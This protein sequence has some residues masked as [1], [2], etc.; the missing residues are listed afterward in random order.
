MA[1]S[2]TLVRWICFSFVIVSLARSF[3][4]CLSLSVFECQLLDLEPGLALRLRFGVRVSA[5]ARLGGNI[6]TRINMGMMLIA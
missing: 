1:V 6:R 5:R 3:R 2:L 4:R